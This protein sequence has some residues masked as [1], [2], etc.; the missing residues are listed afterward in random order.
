MDEPEGRVLDLPVARAFVP[1]LAPARYKGAW[2]GRG[3]AKSHEFAKNLLKRCIEK[4]GTRAVCVREVQRSLEMSVKRLLED[5]IGAFG[6][7]SYFGISNTQITTPGKG[8]IVF[9]GMQ[10]HTADSVKSLEGFGIAWVEEAQALSER[11]MTLLRPTIREP[12]SEL[13]FTWNPRNA[14]DPVDVL[15]RG[16][17]PPPDAIVVGVTYQD[18]PWF[19]DVLQREMEWDRGRDA[20]K[21]Q[22]VWLGGYE[23]HS[24][25]RV[26]RNWKVEEFETP[27]DAVFYWGADWGFSVDPSTLVRCYLAGRTLYVDHEAY[28]IGVEIDHLP[29]FFDSMVCG[30]EPPRPCRCPNLHGEARKWT[31]VADS[32]RPETI[33]YLNRNGYPRMVPAKKGAGSVEE[34]II[35]LQGF[36]I[37]VHPRCVHT[38]DE[39]TS[40]SYKVD[41]AGNVTPVLSDKQ[42]HIIDPLRYAM[43]ELMARGT[44][45]LGYP[46]GVPETS[47]WSTFS[48]GSGSNTKPGVSDNWGLGG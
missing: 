46:E 21:Y 23:R 26:F 19:P 41:A 39:L 45:V 17:N 10:D 12:G 15:L 37:I 9:Q 3:S 38:I 7:E 31:I 27:A 30:C 8:V 24:E 47:I 4:P 25:S 35:F 14:T 13:W 32:A 2:G 34:G 6:L 1:F 44:E 18:N 43:E 11:S 5:K 33:S 42:N 20:E 36:D 40:Y 29:A 48:A 28:S 16:K 22:H